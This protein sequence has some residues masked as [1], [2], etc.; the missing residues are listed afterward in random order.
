MLTVACY[1]WFD[2]LGKNND[3]YTY[4]PE[5]VQILKRMI[6]RNLMM[7]HRFVCITDRIASDLPGVDV[8]SIDKTTHIPGSRYVK[9]MTFHPD[10][11][12]I[13]GER[14]L[15]LDL[16]T[17][18]TGNLDKVVNCPGGDLVL[19]RNPNFG[20]PRRA[21]Y[22]T[23][24]LLL[25]A[26]SRPDIW[27]DFNPSVSPRIMAQNWGGTDQAWISARVGDRHDSYWTDADGVY[28]AGRL[29]DLV[30]GV[31]TDLPSNARVVFFPGRRE[32]GMP[33]T[34]KRHPWIKEYHR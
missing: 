11:S 26:G 4:G 5:H 21:R 10:A 27:N 28:G 32:P 13:I 23:S 7:P 2:P 31:T 14:I 18:I 30:P 1:L 9:L 29:R 33:E 20:V 15:Q 3:L 12:S 19:W 6:E 24:I 17:V 34:Q 25:R 16:D 22:N 8:I